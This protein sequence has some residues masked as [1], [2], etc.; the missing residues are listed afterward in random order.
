MRALALRALS[1]VP[2]SVIVDGWIARLADDSAAR[3]IEYADAL[4]RVYKKPAPWT[5]WG[6]RP[7]PRPPPAVTWQ[8]T[9]DIGEAL[10]RVLADSDR[11]V[12]T[13]TLRRMQREKIPAQLSTLARWLEEEHDEKR[14]GT[15]LDSI[16]ERPAVEGRELLV[17]VVLDGAH[18]MRHRLDALEM[19]TRGLDESSEKRLLEIATAIEDG[20]VLAEALRHLGKR[21]EV[22]SIPLLRR[23]LD[24][25]DP[26]VRSVA[27]QSLARL[28]AVEA[29][30]RVR[31]LLEDDDVRVRRAAASAVGKLAVA[32]A[33]ESL[34]T[35]A[36]SDDLLLKRASLESLRQFGDGRAL[37]IALAALGQPETRQIALEYVADLGGPAYADRLVEVAQKDPSVETLDRVARIL[38]KW[39]TNESLTA[40]RR[41]T[42]DRAIAQVQGRSGVLVRW[43]TAGPLL[44]D[45]AVSLKEELARARASGD[46]PQGNWRTSFGAGTASSL[47]LGSAEGA[48]QGMVWLAFSDAIL[49]KPVEV[50]FLGSSSGTF[51]VWNNGQQLYERSRPGAFRPDSERF[52]ATLAEGRNRFVVQMSASRSVQ[53]HLR[54]RRKS[55]TPERERLTTVA[56]TTKGNTRRGRAVFFSTEKAQCT[57]CHRLGGEGGNVAP[58]LTGV[59]SRFSRIYLI[60]SILEPSR[61]I[62]PSFDTLVVVLG[63]GRVL[64]GVRVTETETTL[65]LADAEGKTHV[66]QKAAI[67]EQ[68]VQP[69]SIMPDG[70]EK[71]LSEREFVDLIAFLLA[72]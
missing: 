55:S 56:L 7:P 63:D 10:D 21:P 11:V 49:E 26:A 64:T 20:A 57:K 72:Q 36:R 70:L 9:A 18:A 48:K 25:L 69:Q 60:E 52:E 1:G 29:G 35:L 46:P 22:A 3:R 54:F 42:L 2:D 44:P 37:P 65:S 53:F 5:Y 43:T 15:I 6:Y 34:L 50:Q 33:V 59:G 66:L 47:D 13:A 17:G 38:T 14:I 45:A 23:K 68:Q 32:G 19:V 12:R 67:S 8:R 27:M 61:T 4:S 51:S 28:G 62:A 41:V 30:T 16:S 31:E 24:S 40:S 58:D 71:Q 39:Q